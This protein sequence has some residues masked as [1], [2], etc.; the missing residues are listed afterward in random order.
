[1]RRITTADG[2]VAQLAAAAAHGD[3]TVAPSF[4]ALE[5]ELL[6]ELG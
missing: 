2:R 1:M 3:R 4:A 6:D 5:A